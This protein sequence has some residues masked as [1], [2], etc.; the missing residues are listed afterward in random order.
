[1]RIRATGF[2]E[3]ES[4]ADDLLEPPSAEEATTEF[5]AQAAGEK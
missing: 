1:V 4:F 2:P 5:E 3:A